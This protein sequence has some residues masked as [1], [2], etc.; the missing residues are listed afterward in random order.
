MCMCD[1]GVQIRAA[2]VPHATLV[3]PVHVDFLQLVRASQTVNATI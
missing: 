3:I 2:V 1:F